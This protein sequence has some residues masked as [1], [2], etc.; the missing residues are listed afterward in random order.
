MPIRKCSVYLLPWVESHF[1]RYQT[2][3]PDM[4]NLRQNARAAAVVAPAPERTFDVPTQRTAPSQAVAGGVDGGISGGFGSAPTEVASA[5]MG[6]EVGRRRG[7]LI[8]AVASILAL[9]GGGTTL[10]F[11][12]RAEAA[13]SAR[14]AH[15]VKLSAQAQLFAD[16]QHILRAANSTAYAAKVVAERAAAAAVATVSL[17]AARVALTAAPQ[18]GDAAR[19]ALQAAIDSTSA[20]LT[21]VP[22]PS[23]LAIQAA[24]SPLAVPQQAAAA[25]QGAW[26]V[27]ED[28]RLAAE[29]LAADEAAQ[30]AAKA[31]AARPARAP[32]TTA[33][34]PAAGAPA[35]AEAPAA[36]V[37]EFSAGALGGAINAWRAGQGLPAMSISR[38]G[39]LV[40]HASAMAEAG[41]IWHSG[42]DKIVGYVQPASAG[43]LVAAWANS[44]GHRDWMAK[45]D[46]TAMQVGAVVLDNK[47]YGAVNFS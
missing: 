22:T 32:R 38:S 12:Q 40:A 33:K 14:V 34:A 36:N 31:Q 2:K 10:A 8:V 21:A 13:E 3:V 27:A 20:V 29:R 24:V 17:E 42:G 47:L 6:G 4:V 43:A 5:R 35:A 39:G 28:A 37:P 41:D 23:V 11:V 19:N 9:G 7:V 45:T 18:A 1:A 15:W 26:Q 46:K 16:E 44:P 25:A 30:A